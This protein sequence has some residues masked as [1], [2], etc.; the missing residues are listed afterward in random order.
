MRRTGTTALAAMFVAAA[1]GL[2]GCES[3]LPLPD[4]AGEDAGEEDAGDGGDGGG[5]SDAGDGGGSGGS[6]AG[7]DAGPPLPAAYLGSFGPAVVFLRAPTTGSQTTPTL[8]VS[9]LRSDAGPPRTERVWITS[10]DASVAR[11]PADGID[12]DMSVSSANV[13]VISML[14]G[15]AWLTAT[16]DGGSQQ[17]QVT[18]LPTVV[19]SEVAAEV[20]GLPGD[21]DDEFVELYNPTNVTLNLAGHVLQYQGGSGAF[22]QIA[23]LTGTIAPYGF[24]LIGF[25]GYSGPPPDL[26]VATTNVLDTQPGSIRLGAPGIG[27]AHPDVRTVD[28]LGWK[29]GLTTA[30][31]FEGTP[32]NMPGLSASW[33]SLERKAQFSSSAA[34]M[35]GVD[36]TLGNA[37]D[38]QSN[39]SDFV[40]K[41]GRGPQN[42]TSPAEVPP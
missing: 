26:F 17:V 15:V 20:S 36:S 35:D 27:T 9:I 8:V 5:V 38:S 19:I 25:N 23:N 31:S 14:N 2:G 39:S 22:G 41:S 18:V 12:V 29:T 10:S 21:P 7:V 42:S 32:V 3:I 30:Q 6:D 40:I 11:V 13:P 1:V 4:D 37:Y 24:Y 28:L 16:F 33:G 34:S